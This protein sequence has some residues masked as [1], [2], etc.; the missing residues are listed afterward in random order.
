MGYMRGLAGL[1]RASVE[2]SRKSCNRRIW[3]LTRHPG[4]RPPQHQTSGRYSANIYIY[5]YIYTYIYVCMYTYIHIHAHHEPYVPYATFQQRG[6]S[7]HQKRKGSYSKDTHK[8][9]P[10][11]SRNRHIDTYI[12]KTHLDMYIYIHRG[13]VYICI[14]M[15]LCIHVCTYIS[16]YIYV[17]VHIYIYNIYKHICY[18]Y[19]DQD[20]PTTL[21]QILSTTK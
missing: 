15:Y 16:T 1:L 12:Y 17:H 9:H 19:I 7:I 18:M 3:A 4:R 20:P 8:K 6:Y 10:L 11:I 5:I 2:V 13:Q 21:Y 14:H